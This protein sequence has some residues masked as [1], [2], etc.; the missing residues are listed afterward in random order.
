MYREA[1]KSNEN[2]HTHEYTH[3]FPIKYEN[4]A[5]HKIANIPR[6]EWNT[7]ETNIHVLKKSVCKKHP[8]M[9]DRAKWWTCMYVCVCVLSI[10]CTL[11]I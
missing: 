4:K 10:L 1:E 3:V 9:P 11:S 6:C 7:I 5:P 2:T 8:H